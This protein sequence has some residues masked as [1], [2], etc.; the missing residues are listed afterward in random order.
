MLAPPLGFLVVPLLG[1]VVSLSDGSS[2][3][4][5]LGVVDVFLVIPLIALA[6]SASQYRTNVDRVLFVLIA[7]LIV[8]LFVT[9]GATSLVLLLLL[10][11]GVAFAHILWRI[12]DGPE[13]T[14]PV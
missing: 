13:P 1:A 6:D 9:R 14:L 5:A 10:V 2:L 12:S 11:Y 7:L 3:R 8:A 4:A